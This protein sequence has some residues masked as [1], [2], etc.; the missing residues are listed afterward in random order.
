[1][2]FTTKQCLIDFFGYGA[3][4]IHMRYYVKCRTSPAE[5]QK[6]PDSTNN[7]SVGRGQS[8]L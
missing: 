2:C 6:L 1:M 3:L 5:K 7:G 4:S 8:I